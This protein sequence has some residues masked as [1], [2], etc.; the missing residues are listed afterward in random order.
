MSRVTVIGDGGWGTA[1]ALTALRNGHQC[2]VWGP[3]PDYLNEIAQRGENVRYLPGVPLPSEIHWTPYHAEAPAD[4]EAVILAVPSRYFNDVVRFFAPYIPR[5]ALVISVTKGLEP[6]TGRRMTEVAS[7]LLERDDVCALSGPSFAEE[8]A[9]GHP[10]AVVVAGYH[11]AAVHAVQRLF[12]GPTFRVYTSRDV[13]GVELGGA[14]KNIIAIAAGVSD[15]IG[16]GDNARAA[17]ATRGLAEMARLGQALGARP[18]TFAGLSGMG[19]LL[20]TCTGRAS[21]NRRV[22]ERLGRGESLSDILA[23]MCQV[24]EGVQTCET[25]RILAAR[26]NVSMP[27]TEAVYA[28]L[29]EGKP[30]ANAVRE[31]MQR[32]LRAEQD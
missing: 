10:T 28:I 5:E 29:R 27:I 14:L 1:L 2:T 21:R 17:L 8:V 11:L 7:A 25:T 15:G 4:A 32:D 12:S 22:G 13:I 6:G 16:F 30:P 31:L 3:F 24:A 20:L 26:Y 19:D 18:E 23:S 9:R